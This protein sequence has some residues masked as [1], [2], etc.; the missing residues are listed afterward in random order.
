[1]APCTPCCRSQNLHSAH[2]FGMSSQ[3]RS[4]LD[5][6]H[7]E[8]TEMDMDATTF[9]P[10]SLIYVYVCVCVCIIFTT[11]LATNDVQH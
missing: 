6:D 4:T 10:A 2:A 1:M 7:Q 8:P 3:G 5:L 9:S 11:H